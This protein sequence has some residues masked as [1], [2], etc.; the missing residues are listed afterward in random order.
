MVDDMDKSAKRDADSDIPWSS[1]RGAAVFGG[2]ENPPRTKAIR[3][4]WEFDGEAKNRKHRNSG[5]NQRRK[6]RQE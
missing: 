6:S 1:M 2:R 3:S 4:V 5:N